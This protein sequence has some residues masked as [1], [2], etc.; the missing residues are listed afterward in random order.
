MPPFHVRV[1]LGMDDKQHNV[2]MAKGKEGKHYGW[3]VDDNVSCP[4]DSDSSGV[5]VLLAL[6]DIASKY[7]GGLAILPR[8]Q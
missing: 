3:H 4:T 1:L 7:G 5:N 6:D 2:F 8:S